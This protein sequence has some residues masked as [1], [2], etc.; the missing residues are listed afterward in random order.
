ME[1][2]KFDITD[3]Q[4]KKILYGVVSEE[5]YWVNKI[6]RK[7]YDT[8]EG[9]IVTL[10]PRSANSVKSPIEVQFLDGKLE[11][12]GLDKDKIR[13]LYK[14]YY[15]EVFKIVPQYAES[16]A[17]S[18]KEIEDFVKDYQTKFKNLMNDLLFEGGF[19]SLMYVKSKIQG[20]RLA[21]VNFG[22]FRVGNHVTLHELS[23]NVYDKPGREIKVG[24]VYITDLDPVVNGEFGGKRPCVVIGHS[25]DK[26]NYYIVPLSTKHY[27]GKS[28]GKIQEQENYAVVSKCRPVSSRRFYEK[29]ATVDD[30]TFKSV[31]SEVEN[32]MLIYSSLEEKEVISVTK[33]SEFLTKSIETEPIPKMTN[34][35]EFQSNNSLQLNMIE[36]N[37]KKLDKEEILQLVEEWVDKEKSEGKRFITDKKGNLNYE[38]EERKGYVAVYLNPNY[39]NAK[40]CY[41]PV[42]LSFATY[43]VFYKY[44]P[45]IGDKGFKEQELTI[46]YQK[47]R[48][49][50]DDTY[51]VGLFAHFVRRTSN[52]YSNLAA[53]DEDGYELQNKVKSLKRNTEA[54]NI[55]YNGDY[56]AL[57]TDGLKALDLDLLYYDDGSAKEL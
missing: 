46:A 3:E 56:E 6:D 45:G 27:L 30:K 19:D 2:I 25:L 22:D 21:G 38:F 13:K 55:F 52:T 44:N 32:N 4:I 26:E 40:E 24:E 34:N 9:T 23:T 39:T 18:K 10:K 28:I 47:K 14:L 41:L 5:Q 50:K 54:L 37:L 35:I 43:Q 8:L 15:Q 48:I 51:F 42:K 57:V 7:D 1:K 49:E 29:V 36:D 16:Y 11:V 17:Q 53:E 31:V 20:Y 12:S 33:T